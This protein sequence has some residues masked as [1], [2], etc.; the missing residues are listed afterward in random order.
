M[1]SLR[2][3][4]NVQIRF[5]WRVKFNQV[6]LCV[7]YVIGLM[8]VVYKYNCEHIQKSGFLKKV[9]YAHQGCISLKIQYNSSIVNINTAVLSIIKIVLIHNSF[10]VLNNSVVAKI[11]FSSH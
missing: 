10:H 11:N 7:V 2:P 1:Y 3:Y 4:R 9:S 6:C 5:C 8:L